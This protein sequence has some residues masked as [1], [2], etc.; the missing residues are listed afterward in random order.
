MLASPPRADRMARNLGCPERR[1]ALRPPNRRVNN[2]GLKPSALQS[3]VWKGVLTPNELNAA[4]SAG[5]A[6]PPFSA[7]AVESGSQLGRLSG[8]FFRVMLSSTARGGGWG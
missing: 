2:F 8:K 4:G 1:V 5:F 6:P 3:L 7:P